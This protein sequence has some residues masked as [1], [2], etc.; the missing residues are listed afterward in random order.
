MEE[1]HTPLKEESIFKT[2]MDELAITMAELAKS[3][4]ELPTEETR[5]PKAIYHTQFELKIEQHS[6]VKKMSI[7][8]LMAQHMNEEIKRA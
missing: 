3:M 1:V 7:G 4:A 6:H 5:T 8:E 2:G